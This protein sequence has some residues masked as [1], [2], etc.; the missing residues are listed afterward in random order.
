MSETRNFDLFPPDGVI[1]RGEGTVPEAWTPSQLNRAVRLL[2]ESSFGSIWVTGEVTNFKRA[3]SGHCYFTLR[4]DEAQVRCVMFRTDAATLPTDPDEGMTV[5]ALGA[6]TLYEA[7]GDCQLVVR[8][9]EGEGA[10]GLWRLAFEKLRARLQGEGLLALERKRAIPDF[11]ACVGVVTSPTG[12]AIRDILS[13]IARR[14]PW[15]RVIVSATRVQGE[16]ASLEVAEAIR[17]LGASG[18]VDVVIAAR[19]GGSIE[20]L[21]AFNEE[22]VARAIVECP[23]PVI[24]AVGHEVDV[25]IADLVA[26]LRAPT[27]SVG[28]EAA[29]PDREA[30]TAVLDG[31]AARLARGLRGS[32]RRRRAS[33]EGQ[34]GRLARALPSLIT[35]RRDALRG[36]SERKLRAVQ[37]TLDAL[38]SRL[39]VAAGTMT[40]LSPL[41]TLHRGYAVPLAPS[42]RVLRRTGD[43]P[44]GLEFSLR[45]VD[46]HVDCRT[47][48]AAPSDEA[49][50]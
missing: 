7:R 14:A 13:V 28:A 50:A 21:W 45:V 4:D 24:S 26:D 15:V 44:E 30:I 37:R 49:R 22:P 46:G 39:Q 47:S 11:P 29:V 16:G 33:L 40:A 32:V 35:P 34:R 8:A 1:E 43:F 6:V 38:R 19:G 9:L 20:D 10:E 3:R 17:S 41:A 25:T 36:L 31:A 12:A 23:V 5:R 18:L 48:G 27:P 2:L 42:G